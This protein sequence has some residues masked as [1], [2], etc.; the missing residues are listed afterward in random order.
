MQ[1]FMKCISLIHS[2][3]TL[4]SVLILVC[5]LGASGELQTLPSYITAKPELSYILPLLSQQLDCNQISLLG[6]RCTRVN[7]LLDNRM[8]GSC[9]QSQ[10]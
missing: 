2:S 10:V 4:R 1:S 3:A 5:W 6:D 9:Y 8:V 7:N